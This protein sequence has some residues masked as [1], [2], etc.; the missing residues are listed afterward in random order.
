MNKAKEQLVKREFDHAPKLDTPCD[1]SVQRGS[2]LTTCGE[3]PTVELHG[4]SR[5]TRGKVV[6]RCE[7]HTVGSS[8]VY[9]VPKENR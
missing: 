7:R 1:R 8:F 3:T 6:H 5:G 9:R 2:D 4:S